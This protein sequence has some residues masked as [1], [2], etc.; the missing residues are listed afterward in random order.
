V[1]GGQSDPKGQRLIL[2]IDWDSLEAIQ[3]TG[4]KIFTGLS[5]GTVKVLRDQEVQ[6]EGKAPDSA[7]SKSGSE[8]EGD[9]TPA[10]SNDQKGAAGARKEIAPNTLSTFS[11]QGTLS[12]DTQ[13]DKKK[14]AEEEGM[15]TGPPPLATKECR[16][17]NK[18]NN[19]NN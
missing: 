9:E 14:K 18:S 11:D 15:E 13:T 8:G 17:G 6:K 3:K 1:L 5:Q 7:S 4:Y 10:P 19:N 2:H 16:E 12:K